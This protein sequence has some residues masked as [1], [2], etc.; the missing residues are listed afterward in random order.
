MYIYLKNLNGLNI[1]TDFNFNEYTIGTI[2]LIH[3]ES[4]NI[5]RIHRLNYVAN[6][7]HYEQIEEHISNIEDHKG[8]L[9]VTLNSNS[10]KVWKFI[11]PIIK[12][13]WESQF[14]HS[15][16]LIIQPNNEL[17]YSSE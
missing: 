8:L 12:K 1:M 17:L 16:N 13:I 2:Q 11:L 9:N 10:R 6:M 4:D 7:I 15:F 14:E 3:S 5:F